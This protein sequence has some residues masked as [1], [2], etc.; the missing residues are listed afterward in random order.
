MSPSRQETAD[1][2]KFTEFPQWTI[3]IFC[4]VTESKCS[5]KNLYQGIL[6]VLQTML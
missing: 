4:T 6:L 3:Q 1:L 5:D 2:V